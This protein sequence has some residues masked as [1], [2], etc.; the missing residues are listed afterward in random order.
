[1]QEGNHVDMKG[2]KSGSGMSLAGL[3]DA[4]NEMRH[5]VRHRLIMMAAYGPGYGHPDPERANI[6]MPPWTEDPAVPLGSAKAN[7]A[8]PPAP[9]SRNSGHAA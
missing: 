6:S 1:L 2:R 8:A 9:K 5:R 7:P 4:V 3:L